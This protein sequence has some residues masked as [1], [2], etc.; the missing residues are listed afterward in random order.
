MTMTSSSLMNACEEVA[1]VAGD[2]AL[3]YYRERPAAETKA[4][5]SPVTVADRAAESAAREWI[6]RRFPGD[7]IIGEEHGTE[8][9]TT[10]RRWIVDPIDGT[11]S[12]VRGVPLWG[13]LIAVCESNVVLAGAVYCPAVGEMLVAGAGE[14]CWRDGVR[15][16]VSTVAT[17]AASTVLSTGVAFP[18]HPGR[19]AAWK[20]LA[21]RADTARTWGDCYGY[22]LVATGRAEVM[23]DAIAND[24]DTAAVQC[25][26]VE[27]GGVFT[28][29]DGNPTAFG[30]SAIATNALV[31]EEA[32]RIL[33]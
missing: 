30:G 8:T 4:D 16:R 12:F 6:A 31:A 11:R 17:I 26:V 3:G 19:C 20:R 7:A 33:R 18:T 14:G 22:L 21:E 15:A 9:G 27:A 32:R 2:I 28:D 24:W 13:T 5:G 23:T 1:R 25:C 10:N 29:W